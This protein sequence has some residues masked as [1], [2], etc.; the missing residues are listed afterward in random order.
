MNASERRAPRLF[1][2]VDVRRERR[3]DGSERLWNVQP[4][5]PYAPN[6]G[7]LLRRGAA[8]RGERVFL[9][10]RDGDQ[11]R[12]ITYG[13]MLDAVRRLASALLRMGLGRET[14][15]AILSENSIA[16]AI[17]SL[18]AL[19][20]GIPVAP[21][22]PA[23]S[24]QFGDLRRLQFILGVLQPR[25][26]FAADGDA[27]AN[28][29]A[30][31]GDDI[32]VMIDRGSSPRGDALVL[33]ELLRGEVDPALDAAEARV[34]P[35]DVAKI[36][37]TSG[38][39][40]EPKGVIN[41]HRMLC[42][43]QQ[44]LAQLWPLLGD[45]ELVLVDWLPWHHTFGGNHN[46]N[47]A[48]QHGGA[49][50]I[51]RGRPLPAHFDRSVE[52]LR[53]VPPTVYFNVP[54]GH[55]LLV[56]ALERD[57]AFARR[58]FS[59]LRLI[60]NAAAGL[61]RTTWEALRS[62]ARRYGGAEV[63]VTGAWGLTETSPMATAVH[64][65]LRDPA[66]I[67]LPGPG[68]ELLFVPFEHKREVRVRGPLVTPGYWRRDD[69]TAAAFDEE[70]FYRT[71]DA[72]RFAADDDPALGLLFDGRLAENFKLT[73]GTWVDAGAVRI[74]LLGALA[75]LV[76]DVV[77]A[78]ENRDAIAALLFARAPRHDAIARALEAY[79]ASAGGSSCCVGRAVT[80]AEPL[81]P[82]D[83]ELTDKG[84]V[85]QRRVLERRAATVEHAYADPPADD[86][87]VFA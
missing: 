57:D 77:V 29:L 62:L 44:S 68:T 70:G 9:G 73:T 8:E 69:L 43:N 66:D 46:F 34:G 83:G 28:A 64:Y 25:L 48:L 81:S 63:A 26:V 12:T 60:G 49:L 84:S 65:P 38:S 47:M 22:S 86:V 18:S 17:V 74:A 59:R 19:D 50:Y 78:G 3:P 58:F 35:D 79:N 13:A 14:P 67:G 1:A 23:Y 15:I 7:A 40:G 87:L 71:G 5:E 75:G 39:T 76:D 10:E 53:D 24:T 4:L 37:F 51:D 52:T 42:S 36:L 56:A 16:H 45:H 82:A 31:V 54:R 27:Y 20:A 30:L 55:A 6:V 72:V 33:G 32:A 2:P 21:I 61:P 80:V 11:W 85:N 41:T